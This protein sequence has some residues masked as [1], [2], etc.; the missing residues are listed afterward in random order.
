[1]T[2]ENSKQ[3]PAQSKDTSAFDQMAEAVPRRDIVLPEDSDSDGGEGS[4]GHELI[5]D[6]WESSKKLSDT[7]VVIRQLFPDLGIPWLNALQMGRVFAEYHVDLKDI[8]TKDLIRGGKKTV[9]E[10]IALAEIAVGIADNGE[11]RIDALAAIR[12]AAE[13]EEAKNKNDMLG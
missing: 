2:T 6:R 5:E 11:G 3:Q 9:A 13:A 7:Q 12:G 1:M 8:I 10:A 4:D